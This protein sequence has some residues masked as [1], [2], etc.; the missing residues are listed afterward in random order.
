MRESGRTIGQLARA[1]GVGVE[2]VRYYERRGL[3]RQPRRPAGG[4][5]HY[6]E[7]A[8]RLIR[9]IRLG[10]G[11]GLSL[12]DIEALLKRAHDTQR[13]F[14]G[15]VRETVEEK[16]AAVRR[17][18]RALRARERELADFLAACA[19]RDPALACPILAGLGH[20]APT[21]RQD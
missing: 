1:A 9:Y 10:R 19:G 13:L 17:D 14:C 21:A 4:F 5:R 6:D 7:D 18:L 3:L 20:A 11:L 15:A 16:L 12:G 8:L 2:T